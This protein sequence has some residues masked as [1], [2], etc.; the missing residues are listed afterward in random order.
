MDHNLVD[1]IIK[2]SKK[3]LISDL[4]ILK[5]NSLKKEYEDIIINNNKKEISI[6]LK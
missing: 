3:Y 4:L 6:F 5:K 1:S 2:Q